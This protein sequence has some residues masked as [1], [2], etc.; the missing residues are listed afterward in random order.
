MTFQTDE[1][2][3]E[4]L[5]KPTW[6]VQS[7][8]P[9]KEQIEQTTE[10]TPKQLRHLLKLSALSLPE[11]PEEEEQLLNGLKSQLHFVK[12]I[13]KV[14]TRGVEPLRSLRDESAEAGKENEIGM[15]SLKTALAQ[16]EIVGNHH[17]RVRRKQDVGKSA[18]HVEEWD[19]LGQAS[20][21]V[22]KYFVVHHRG[23]S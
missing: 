13:Q 10:V 16:E 8:L 2:L 15:E 17:K 4:F 1:D 9:T 14:N 20:S 19:V 18:E 22:G 21:K 11:T 3:D 12:E 7:L 6:S 23:E 5:S